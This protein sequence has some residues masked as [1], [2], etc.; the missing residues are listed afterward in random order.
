[1]I[2]RGEFLGSRRVVHVPGMPIGTTSFTARDKSN[3]RTGIHLKVDVIIVAGARDAE[4][5]NSVKNF[6]RKCPAVS[7]RVIDFGV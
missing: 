4:Y 3:V 1:M 6:I 5:F 7:R 2:K